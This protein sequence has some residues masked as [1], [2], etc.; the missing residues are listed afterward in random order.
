MVAGGTDTSANTLAFAAYELAR[1]PDVQDRIRKELESVMESTAKENGETAK[2]ITNAELGRTP[3]L[4]N[5][6]REVFRLHPAVSLTFR[7]AR[8]D[9][10][11]NGYHVPAGTGLMVN[12]IATSTDPKNY[13]D[14]LTFNPERPAGPEF[15]STPFG[16]GMRNCPGQ[17]LAM[18]EIKAV[19]ANI[20]LRYRFKLSSPNQAL[21][22][23]QRR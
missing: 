5:V 16:F 7:M 21:T 12:V 6:I 13:D 3:Y 19:L 9:T 4:D 22:A 10:E 15:S 1:H 18:E 8:V 20:C 23:R 17:S 11:L 14:P 2:R